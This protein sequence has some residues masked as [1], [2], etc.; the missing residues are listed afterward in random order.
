MN[1]FI[2][3]LGFILLF[4]GSQLYWLFVAVAA[5]IAGGA[6][7]TQ[8]A[9]W[10]AHSVSLN[11]ALK[12]SLLGIVFAITSKPLAVL[13]AGFVCGGYLTYGFPEL[14]GMQMGWYVWPFFVLGGVLSVLLLIFLYS[15]GMIL[16]TSFTGAVMILQNVTFLNLD[17]GAAFALF[18]LIGILA[19]LI[20]FNYLEP[21]ID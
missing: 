2:V 16:L 10:A 9:N 20:L 7:Q 8:S 14:L 15:L 18:L 12:Y 11:D 4:A 19:Q 17:Q 1:T 13:A 21:S 5:L 6:V 3:L